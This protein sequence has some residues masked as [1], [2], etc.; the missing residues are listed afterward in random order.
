MTQ[1]RE[2][3]D[4]A[5]T[6]EGGA[7][8][9]QAKRVLRNPKFLALFGSQIFTQVGGNMV[10]FGLTVTVFGLTDSN[11][12]V[13]L[14]LLTFLVPAVVFGAIAGVF[15]DMFDRRQILV[16]TNFARGAL[17]M[18][19]IFF[20]DQL[21][22]IY[23]VTALV[24]TLTTFF[25]P[26][27]AAMI[28]LVV[29]REQLMTA[30]SLFILMLQ[31]SFV[32][33]FALLGPLA[34]TVLGMRAARSSSWPPPTASPACSAGSCPRRHRARPGM[35]SLASA[36][37]AIN[38]TYEQLKEGL[39]YI[40][41]HH[42]IAWSLTYLAIT[43]S[44]IG[45]LGSL[46]PAFAKDVLGLEEGD[47]VVILL[48]LGAGLV[49]G[50]VILNLIGK[51]LP[52]RRLI[53]GGMIALAISLVILGLAQ[54]LDML[55]NGDDITALIAVVVV[56]AFAAG[57]CYAFVAVPA[58]T[59]LQEELPSDVRG[60]VFGVLNMLVEPGL[61]R[62]HHHGRPA[63]RLP[64]RRG[65]HRHL[66]A[67]R[68]RRRHR[69]HHL[70]PPAHHR[71]RAAGQHRAGR[72]HDRDHGLVHAEPAHPA[73]LHRRRRRG[74][75][76]H[77]DHR[78]PGRAGQGWPRSGAPARPAAWLSARASSV[79]FTGGTISMLP[80][81][82]TGAAVPTLD[83]AAILA[84][85]PGPRRHRRAGAGRLGPGACLAPALRPDPRARPRSSATPPSGPTSTAWSWS[86]APTCSRRRPSPGTCCTP[87][88]TPVVVVGRHA[89]RR[90]PRLR[91]AAQPHRR[92]PRRGRP[93]PARGRAWSW[94]WPG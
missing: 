42:N 67:H 24:A 54:N 43:A 64:Q 77:P 5:I 79:I 50:I 75:A 88:E 19:L 85:V 2:Q 93:A 51:Y 74:H 38:A 90:R 49:S 73:A 59:S 34:H 48:P 33:G 78:Q 91:R 9:D 87:R 17:Y 62:A 16:W 11:T 47:L 89:Q 21:I 66:R 4:D 58:Q 1:I 61:V 13:S 35:A 18:L 70:R 29:K 41:D 80:D 65:R 14:L 92:R 6:I 30:N 57:V 40:R 15:V 94:S 28:P 53:E 7:D 27:E 68:R 71:L 82:V 10:L 32:L 60:R 52:R 8:V 83:G 45:V 56:V 81:P 12:S 55:R 3:V 22:V 76:T 69:L 20:P 44:L 31:A 25:G 63:G 72:P 36:R 37:S 84:R 39:Q 86:R 46:G 26:A 23:V